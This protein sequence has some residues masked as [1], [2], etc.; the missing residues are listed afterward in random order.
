MNKAVTDEQIRHTAN[1][2]K[3]YDIAFDT[4]NMLGL[5]EE[6]LLDAWRTIHLNIDINAASSWTSIFQ[7]YPK[8]AIAS[9]ISKKNLMKRIDIENTACDAHT[10]SPLDQPDIKKI[11]NLHKFIYLVTKFPFI[12]PAVELLILFPPNMIFNL[13]YRMSYL[14]F[15]YS[16]AKHLGLSRTLREAIKAAR[17]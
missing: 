9:Y 3:K 7:P 14:V 16:K 12:K 15:F 5:P 17:Y 2:L 8:T 1:L 11:E 10:A 4:T 6:S 13:I